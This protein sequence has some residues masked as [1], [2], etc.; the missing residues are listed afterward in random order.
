MVVSSRDLKWVLDQWRE[1]GG[2]KNGLGGAWKIKAEIL[3]G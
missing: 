1:F 2:V 3:N